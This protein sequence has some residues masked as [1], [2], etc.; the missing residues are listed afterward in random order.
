MVREGLLELHL[1]LVVVGLGGARELVL[2]LEARAKLVGILG[3]LRAE[4]GGWTTG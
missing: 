4:D 3:D 2:R 1:Q